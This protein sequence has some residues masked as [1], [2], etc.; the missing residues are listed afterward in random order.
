MTLEQFTEE[1]IAGKWDTQY[2]DFLMNKKDF[3][4][5]E[6]TFAAIESGDYDEE[7]Y[8]FLELEKS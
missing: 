8:E 4:G 5:K 1:V 7:F 6:K 3:V 2:W